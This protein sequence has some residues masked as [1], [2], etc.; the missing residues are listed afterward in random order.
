MTRFLKWIMGALRSLLA[1]MLSQVITFFMLVLAG[2][3]WW[4][5]SSPFAAIPVVIIGVLIGGY[6]YGVVEGEPNKKD[7]E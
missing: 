2:F 3:A 4:Y 7:G 1:D 6:T 5:F